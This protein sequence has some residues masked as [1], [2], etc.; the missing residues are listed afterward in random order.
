[1]HSTLNTRLLPSYYKS[2][3]PGSATGKVMRPIGKFMRPVAGR[4]Q[5]DRHGASE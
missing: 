3:M 1:M 5:S 4:Q 2:F